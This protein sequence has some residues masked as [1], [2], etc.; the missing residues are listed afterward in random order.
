MKRFFSFILIV[1][2]LLASTA[3]WAAP[4]DE[5]Y[6]IIE[7]VYVDEVDSEALRAADPADIG[8]VLN[9]PH[10]AYFSPDDFAAF[11]EGYF[12]TFGG[13]GTAIVQEEEA[14]LIQTVF[15]GSPAQKAGLMPGDVI[16]AVDDVSVQGMPLDM[17]ATLIRG[18]EGTKVNILIRRGS[19]ELNKLI[20]REIIVIPT[21]S[22]FML[23]DVAYL[24]IHSFSEQTP[25][26]FKIELAELQKNNPRG[27]I[28]DLR[29]NP[30][31]S[32]DAVLEIADRILP[33][34]P[35]IWVRDRFGNEDSYDNMEAGSLLPNLAV[36]INNGSASGS[37]ILAGAV[38]DYAVGTIIGEQSYGKASVQTIFMLSD[39][40]GLKVTTARYYTA[41]N[42]S[43]D[44]VGLTPDILVESY[45]EQLETAL[46]QVRSAS[47]TLVFAIGSKSAWST[48]GDLQLDASPYIEDGRSYIPVRAL[49]EAMGAEVLWDADNR[50]AVLQKDGLEIEIPI[51]QSQGLLNGEP[52]ELLGSAQLRDS[53]T[54]VPA[55]A[56]AEALGGRV[57]W[58]DVHH[59]VVIDW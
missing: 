28:I 49:G 6:Q 33:A 3:A 2:M 47:P 29:D 23:G 5:I 7:T 1:S 53:R 14:T 51:G 44:K 48:A 21:M 35:R 56:V 15:P 45:P 24:G 38:Q 10:T 57:W 46:R 27:Y 20:V 59:E 34:G 37:E 31:G 17:V 19:T 18:E 32:L 55:R 52:F 42:Q 9:D 41:K 8:K 13:I 50:T 16:V 11:M 36:L 43:I 40:S 4:L 22:S 58:D 54:Y 30:G 12:G 25:D 39:N 26:A